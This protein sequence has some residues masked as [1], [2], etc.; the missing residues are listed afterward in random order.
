M[1]NEKIKD[2][3][4]QI[5]EKVESMRS[6]I[7]H[8]L[9]T[10]ESLSGIAVGEKVLIEKTLNHKL[11]EDESCQIFKTIIPPNTSFPK[12]WHD[13][14]EQN[15]ILSGDLSCNGLIYKKGHWMKFECLKSHEIFND[16]EEDSVI[17]VIF[18]R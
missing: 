10:W 6:V 2:L 4:N 9:V 7:F 11:H 13:F 12:H 5:Q 8:E 3:I 1:V 17:I 15:L 14:L 18:T 16:T